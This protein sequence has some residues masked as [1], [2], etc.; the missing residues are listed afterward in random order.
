M[1]PCNG[2]FC[3]IAFLVVLFVNPSLRQIFPLPTN[4]FN[5]SPPELYGFGFD[6]KTNDYKFLALKHG[7][8]SDNGYWTSELY[9]LN[10]NTWK[11]IDVP[12]YYPLPESWQ[13]STTY[14]FVKNCCHWWGLALDESGKEEDYVLAFDMLV[15]VQNNNLVISRVRAS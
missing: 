11:D 10:S 12:P 9:S 2:I 5:K 4:H 3:L 14:T 15:S 1:G 8:G 13:F 6:S 7:S